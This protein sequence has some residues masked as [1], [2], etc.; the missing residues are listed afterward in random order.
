LIYT[1]IP[2]ETYIEVASE[3]EISASTITT[4]ALADELADIKLDGRTWLNDPNP[5]DSSCEDDLPTN[6]KILATE[7]LENS[8]YYTLFRNLLNN[9]LAAQTAFIRL[10]GNIVRKEVKR[11]AKQNNSYLKKQIDNVSDIEE[12]DWDY[13][14][15]EAKRSAPFLSK[16]LEEALPSAREMGENGPRMGRKGHKRYNSCSNV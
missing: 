15:G 13:L 8:K 16:M 1:Q 5:L 14:V 6:F 7:Q 11:T 2:E 10:M 3:I 9:S 12:F 4:S